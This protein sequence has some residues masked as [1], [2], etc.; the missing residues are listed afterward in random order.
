MLLDK[1]QVSIEILIA[2]HAEV[3]HVEGC[4][5]LLQVGQVLMEVVGRVVP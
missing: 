3:R 4:E 5:Q 2:L 1:R